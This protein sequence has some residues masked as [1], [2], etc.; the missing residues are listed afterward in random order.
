MH[1]TTERGEGKNCKKR[2]PIYYSTGFFILIRKGALH[3]DW[4]RGRSVLISAQNSPSSPDNF[5]NFAQLIFL[6]RTDISLQNIIVTQV[7]LI[8]S[9]ISHFG[10]F[11]ALITFS[12]HFLKEYVYTSSRSPLISASTLKMSRII[13][14]PSSTQKSF[15]MFGCIQLYL[16]LLRGC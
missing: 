14:F 4:N 11:L 9:E 16:Y 1:L 7:L 8:Q 5:F 13:F 2:V 3:L 10:T 6:P 12:A 15:D